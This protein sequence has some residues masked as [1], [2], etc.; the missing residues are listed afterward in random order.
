MDSSN[1]PRKTSGRGVNAFAVQ[2]Y[3]KAALSN[4]SARYAYTPIHAN[5]SISPNSVRNR[6]DK[7]NGIVNACVCVYRWKVL[8]SRIH[9]NGDKRLRP[10][11]ALTWNHHRSVRNRK[12][13]INNAIRTNGSSQRGQGLVHNFSTLRLFIHFLAGVDSAACLRALMRFLISVFVCDRFLYLSV[14]SFF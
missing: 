9:G 10:A 7:A 6:A 4:P 11:F 13:A 3:T 8:N 1:Y 2:I 14:N 5:S 12:R